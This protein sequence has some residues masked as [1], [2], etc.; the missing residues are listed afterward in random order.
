[1]RCSLDCL[2]CRGDLS[3]CSR[4]E[5]SY[6][7]GHCLIGGESGELGLPEIEISPGQLVE[8]GTRTAWR[9][10]VFRGHAAL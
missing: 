6:L 5:S 4:E 3:V 2:E 1:M 7:L 10:V 8:I 9:V